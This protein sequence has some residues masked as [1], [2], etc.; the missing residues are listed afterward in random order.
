MTIT[1]I[2]NGYRRPQNLKLQLEALKYQT[3][4][5]DEIWLWV[6]H[7]SG[8]QFQKEDLDCIDKISVNNYN[9]KYVGRFAFAMLTRTENIALFD[10]DTVPGPEWLENCLQNQT[11]NEGPIGGIGLIHNNSTEYMNHSREG[12]ASKNNKAIPVDLIGHAWFI[13]RK[14]MK[15][16]WMEDPVS[17]DTAED[18]HLC[19]TFQKYGNL[20][21]YVPPQHT[22]KLSSSLLGYEL[23]VDSTTPSVTD[24]KSFFS[25]RDKCLQRYCEKGWQLLYS[26]ECNSNNSI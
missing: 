26:N 3:I 18:M 10:D 16:F 24:H 5:P 1:V 21:A 25:L 4:K 20:Q 13:K 7:Y 23:G 9:H 12:W 15:Y 17:W 22:P 14:H 8:V 2:L 19:Y 11:I 6:N